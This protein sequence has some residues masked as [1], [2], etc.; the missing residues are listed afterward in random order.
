M[1][2]LKDMLT[3]IFGKNGKAILSGIT[4]GKAIDEIIEILSPNVRKKSSQIR[5]I[6]NKEISQSAVFRLHICLKLINHFD[7]EIKSLEKEIFIYAYKI[8]KRE[9]EILMSVP[10]IGELGAA[11]LLAEIGNF[12]DFLP[13][14]SLLPSLV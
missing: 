4:S 14:I 12:K 1:F 7:N 6:L 9:M 5:D 2:N 10:G 13:E 3:D 11:I 8:H